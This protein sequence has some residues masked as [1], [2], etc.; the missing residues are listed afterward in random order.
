MPNHIGHA[1]EGHAHKGHGHRGHGPAHVHL[2]AGAP[3]HDVLLSARA[4]T[5][6]RSG[7]VLLDGVDLDVG[8]REIVTLIGPNGAGKTTLV[9]LLLGID[10]PDSGTI[11][12]ASDLRIGYVPQR[13]EVERAIPIDVDRFLKLGT[14]STQAD[15]AEALNR[16]G[17]APTLHLQLARLSG[18][19]LQ[20]VLL[21]RALLHRPRLLVLDEP[22]RGVDF[23][24][25]AELYA[26]IASLRDTL[27]LGVLLVSHDL[28]VVMA[29][30]DRVLCLNRHVCCSGVPQ[31]VAQH[32]EYVRLFGPKAARA[33]AIYHHEHDHHHDIAGEP[34]PP[35]TDDG[36]EATAHGVAVDV[37][38]PVAG[39][40]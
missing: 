38:A 18:G 35:G 1:H 19:E 8:P 37:S 15:I 27:D 6:Q 22:T 23:T 33:L 25:E 29:A 4:L 21:A 39:D 32:P 30:S 24:G 11:H 36:L 20:R 28:H 10:K 12:R 5:V 16:V 3:A 13:F 26:L 31:T 34:V 17:A 40:R 7:R 14:K 2:P 9:R